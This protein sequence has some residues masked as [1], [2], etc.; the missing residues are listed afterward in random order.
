MEC[1]VCD[2]HVLVPG[3]T[4]IAAP[5][6]T[7]RAAQKTPL[8][9]TSPGCPHTVTVQPRKS[10]PARGRHTEKHTQQRSQSEREGNFT[11]VKKN[12]GFPSKCK[13]NFRGT[14]QQ[15]VN[16]PAGHLQM[17]CAICCFLPSA[18]WPAAQHIL[19]GCSCNAQLSATTAMPFP[20]TPSS[21]HHPWECIIPG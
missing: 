17:S 11:A 21:Q 1:S 12:M 8:H 5:V 19:Q 2:F 16:A 9:H 3:N 14:P 4:P 15:E 7:S 6:E 13:I 20:Q 10:Q 18:S